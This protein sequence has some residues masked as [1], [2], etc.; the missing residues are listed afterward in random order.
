MPKP[1][2]KKDLQKLTKD[3]LIEQITDLYKKYKPVKEYYNF[4][5][6]PDEQDLFEK[7]REIISNEFYP[8]KGGPKMRFSIAKKAISDFKG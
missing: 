2:L 1:N 5:L 6:N 8:K 4:Y 7:Y 3:Q